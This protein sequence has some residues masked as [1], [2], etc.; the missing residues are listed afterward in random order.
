MNRS[1]DLKSNPLQYRNRLRFPP[2]LEQAYREDYAQKA[3]RLQRLF[4]VFGFIL[5]GLFGILDYWAMPQNYKL[6]WTFRAVVESFILALFLVSFK[7]SFQ[8]RMF[9]LLNLWMLVV[10]VSILAMI[11]A[12]QPSELAYTYYP[13]GLLLPMISGYVISGDLRYSSVVGWLT[14]GGYFFIGIYDQHA[15]ASADAS[16]QFFTL[17]FF[18]IS[19]NIIGM[20]VGYVL[21][22]SKRLDFLHRQVI[23]QQN[24]ETE[25]LRAESE[26]LLLNVLPVSIA[27]R[28]KRFDPIADHFSDAS[29]LFA[30]L[31]GFTEFSACKT[32]S[33]IVIILNRIF[34]EFDRL[35]ER[36]GLEKIKTIGDAYMVVS[37][38]PS[39][40]PDHL[41]TIAEMALEMQ[42]TIATL[43]KE[44]GF[45]LQ[46]RVGINSGPVVAG[47]IGIKKFSYDLW[48]DTVNVASRMEAL[49]LPGKIQVSETVY[50]ALKDR[51]TFENRGLIP[52]KGKGAM[53]AYLLTGHRETPFSNGMIE[54]IPSLHKQSM[55]D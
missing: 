13:I 29:I 15:L 27:E 44:N 31:V 42:H 4:I 54:N 48:G 41:E 50:Q 18:L 33:E 55:P 23:E 25:R 22:L 53:M 47:I 32:P 6:A 21:E 5:Y 9:W 17:N 14:I 26:R 3:I 38:L 46:L 19:M 16:L 34:S 8:M 28:L 52:V 2:T 7:K 11:A 12:A 39:T 30:D 36:Y 37:G 51:F 10:N 49:G 45:N 1:P 40:R 20:I 43:G 35:T 24:R